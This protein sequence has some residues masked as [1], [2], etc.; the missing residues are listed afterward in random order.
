MP[1][2]KEYKY[3]LRIDFTDI[4]LNA[5]KHF[6]DILN[7]EYLEQ[8]Y[9]GDSRIRSVKYIMSNGVHVLNH[10][11]DEYIFTFKRKIKNY[12]FPWEINTNINKDDFDALWPECDNKLSKTRIYW[13]DN[14]IGEWAI[15]LFQN[16]KDVYF[17]MVEY[18]VKVDTGQERPKLP[19][20]LEPFLIY[21]VDVGDRRFTSKSLA[22]ID[23]AEK[24]SSML[25]DKRVKE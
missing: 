4:F 10:N 13:N 23:H 5:L 14:D 20:C 15:D 6:H 12:D 19:E 7:V 22:D 2:E 17:V 9:M 16:G 24:I 21:E 3:V 25:M 1:I 8:G 11:D 18:E